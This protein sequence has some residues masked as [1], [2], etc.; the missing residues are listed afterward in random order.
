MQMMQHPS[1][2]IT[3]REDRDHVPYHTPE[4]AKHVIWYQIF[5]ERFNNGDPSNDPTAERVEGPEGWEISDWT[6]DWYEQADWEKDMGSRFR[7]GVFHRRYGGDLQGIIDKL[8]YLQDLGVSGLYLNPVFDAVSLH[9]YDTSYYHHVDRFFGPD[10]EG[11]TKIMEQE[12]HNDPSTWQWTS[13]DK[14]FLKLIEEVHN[15]DMKI[16]I[17]GVF[18]HSGKDFW[19]FRDLIKKQEDSS[20]KDWYDVISFDN[21]NG[22]EFDYHGWWGVKDLP[23]F[24]GNGNSLVDP[25]KEHI[26]DITRRWMDPDGD[27]DPSDGIDGWRLDVPEEVGQQFWIE[28]HDLVREV[29]PQSFTVG[30]I[31]TDNAVHYI[32]KEQFNASMNYRFFQAVQDYMIDRDIS[33]QDFSNR[34][35]GIRQSYPDEANYVMQ[36]LLDSHDTPRIASIIVN[37]GR[38]FDQWGLP[39]DGFDVRKPNQQERELQKLIALFQ[40]TYVGAPMIYYGTEAGMWGA[41]DPDD[42]K[43]MVWPDMEFENESTHPVEGHERPED[44]NFFD[45]DIY[46]WYKKLTHIRNNYEALRTGRYKC[47]R[48]QDDLFIFGRHFDKK[49]PIIVAINRSGKEQDIEVNLSKFV[50]T[51]DSYKELLNDMELTVSLKNTVRLTLPAI[52]GAILVPQ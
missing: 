36:N 42:R 50:T 34:L 25:V 52:S 46:E 15:R 32:N 18:N 51:P 19:A 9:K 40:F 24:R 20:F 3:I 10:P 22:S 44:Q 45:E 17:D 11:D 28:W 26:F 38:K 39:A 30:E 4:W 16:I 27:G 7:S 31:W 2:D 47:I 35:D 33:V 37:A 14:L 29:N 13:A 23:E 49:N 8:D 21:Q 6:G 41:D 12:D 43:P 1:K 5:P 48:S